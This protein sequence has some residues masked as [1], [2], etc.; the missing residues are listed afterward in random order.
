V[1]QDRDVSKYVAR[2]DEDQ[3]DGQLEVSVFGVRLAGSRRRLRRRLAVSL[4]GRRSAGAVTHSAHPLPL[5]ACQ[6]GHAVNDE[7]VDGSD[8]GDRH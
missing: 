1:Q 5:G 6:T 2:R 8:D 7:R 3:D 4:S